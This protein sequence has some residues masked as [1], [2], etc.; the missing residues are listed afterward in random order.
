MPRPADR[1][2]CWSPF[3][4]FH[5]HILQMGPIVGQ[6][7][8][9]H[10]Q[11]RHQNYQAFFDG[12]VPLNRDINLPELPQGKPILPTLLTAIVAITAIAGLGLIYAVHFKPD[13]LEQ[14]GMG[15][16]MTEFTA[17][18]GGG[19]IFANLALFAILK[20]DAVIRER[21]E[22]ENIQG[23]TK[24]TAFQ[25]ALQVFVSNV[26]E[27]TSNEELKGN[28][29]A[30]SSYDVALGFRYTPGT[31]QAVQDKLKKLELKAEFNSR[32]DGAVMI[33]V[34]GPIARIEQW[35]RFLDSD[36]ELSYTGA[37][38]YGFFHAKT[39]EEFTG[40][41][42]LASNQLV[43]HGS[44]KERLLDTSTNAAYL[45]DVTN[46]PLALRVKSLAIAMAGVPLIGVFSLAYNVVKLVG[47]IPYYAI[48]ALRPSK[49]AS[50]ELKTMGKSLVQA[51]VGI[52]MSFVYAT[53]LALGCVLTLF[54]PYNGRKLMSSALAAWKE[55]FDLPEDFFLEKA[56][57]GPSILPCMGVT[58]KLDGQRVCHYPSMDYEGSPHVM[59]GEG[60]Q[61]SW[62]EGAFTRCW[63][64]VL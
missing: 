28:L 54:D 32:E 48:Q 40:V 36:N 62:H 41:E 6:S 34:R 4:T 63:G 7:H 29:A 18:V 12:R 60:K 49:S 16:T 23:A 59:V 58:Q 15:L 22:K 26:T 35:A 24:E 44:V 45:N 20:V 47:S 61:A 52:P 10:I 30:K 9:K 64:S 55:S 51:A 39:D 57:E 13:L 14:I 56:F 8:W 37:L 43:V 38:R 33:G 5:H 11:L 17:M 50:E 19:I 53:L 27:G 2:D 3:E 21:R 1:Q 42:S 31:K 25:Q 46:A